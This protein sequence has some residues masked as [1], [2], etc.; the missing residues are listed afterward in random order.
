MSFKEK[1]HTCLLKT[2]MAHNKNQNLFLYS[3]INCI[4]AR[5]PPQILFLKDEHT[6]RFSNILIND[7]R[8]SSANCHVQSEI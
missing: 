7:W 5:S 3:L 4:S 1:T 6:L 8:N 2:S